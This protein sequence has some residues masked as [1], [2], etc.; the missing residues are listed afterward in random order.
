MPKQKDLK[1]LARTRMKKTGESYTAARLQLLE[2]KNTP[3]AGPDPASVA[4]MSDA[5][6]R[7][8]T[9][10]T[11]RQWALALDAVEATKMSHRDIA[12]HLGEVHGLPG[13]WAQM[14]AVG[15]ER[16]RGLR[17]V[18]QRR[19]GGYE[20]HRSKTFTAPV[21][22]LYEA[23]ATPRARKRW[24]SGVELTVRKGTPDRSLRITWGDGTP[25]Q[26]SFTAKGDAKSQVAIQHG[27]LADKASAARMKA[28]WAERLDALAEILG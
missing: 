27:K 12:A 2:T 24:L 21:S 13:W 18:G 15:Y 26:L 1:R 8:K 6:V 7:S 22:K 19:G 16:I 28:F 14:V 25:V 3:S 10:R 20:A 9:G 4:G 23:F 17:D 5:A 11:W